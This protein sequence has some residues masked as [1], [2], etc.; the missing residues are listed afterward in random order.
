M[1]LQLGAA[2][3]VLIGMTAWSRTLCN[4]DADAPLILVV[5]DEVLVRLAVAQ[6]LRQAGYQVLEAR[7]ADEALRLLKKADVDAVFSDIAM[8]GS[9]DG[10]QLADWLRAHRPEVGTVLTSGKL[11][12]DGRYEFF[13]GKPYRL[14]D[15]DLCLAEMLHERSAE[16]LAPKRQLA[17]LPGD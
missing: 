14:A 3:A 17:A 12:P 11:Q 9:I 1:P 6:H 15:L 2:V 10:L 7:N 5:E 16:H 13:L 8:P 4:A